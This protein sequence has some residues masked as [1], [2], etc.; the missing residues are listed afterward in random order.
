MVRFFIDD[1]KGLCPE[2]S[3]RALIGK[4]LVQMSFPVSQA[5]IHRLGILHDRSGSIGS[6]H[7]LKRFRQLQ[8]LLLRFGKPVG[9]ISCA[10]H[11]DLFVQINI[12]AHQRIRK[13]IGIIERIHQMIDAA[14]RGM[15]VF[16]IFV[17]LPGCK[18]ILCFVYIQ[19]GQFIYDHDDL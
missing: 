2:S 8:K 10:C 9:I 17:R 7:F 5:G 16:R 4:V 15:A 1:I 12:E 3:S 6:G 13:V 19:I 11:A 14:H 18:R